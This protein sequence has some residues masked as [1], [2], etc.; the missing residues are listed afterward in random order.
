MDAEIVICTSCGQSKAATE[1]YKRKASRH[2]RTFQ[3]KACLTEYKQR[4][5][6]TGRGRAL[7]TWYNIYWR[8][9]NRDGHHPQY[10]DVTLD[11]DRE[12]FL[13]WAVPALQKFMDANPDVVPS[14]DRIDPDKSY[15]IDNLR[16]IPLGENSRLA[17]HEYDAQ[18]IANVALGYCRSYNIDPVEVASLILTL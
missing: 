12:Q 18:R 17:R 7:E 16:V 6:A 15:H 2:G 8:S 1:F 14:V 3:C 11:I 4:R 13:L 9:E 10:A 5:R